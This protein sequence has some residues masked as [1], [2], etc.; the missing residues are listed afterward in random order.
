MMIGV[1]TKGAGYMRGTRAPSRIALFM[2]STAR[3]RAPGEE[4]VER[5]Q[6]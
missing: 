5:Q 4:R 3:E 1:G 2:A 6:R